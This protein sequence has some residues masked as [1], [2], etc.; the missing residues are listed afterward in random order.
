M[1]IV[2]HDTRPRTGIVALLQPRV[3]VLEHRG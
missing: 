2:E 3:E 1:D